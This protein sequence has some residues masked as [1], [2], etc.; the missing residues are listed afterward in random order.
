MIV[1]EE[2]CV[3]ELTSIS[4]QLKKALQQVLF[5]NLEKKNGEIRNFLE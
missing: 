2:A 1:I 5:Y 4:T 3:T